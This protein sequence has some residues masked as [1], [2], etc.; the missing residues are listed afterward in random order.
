MSETVIETKLVIT[1]KL[2]GKSPWFPE[3]K[4][5]E[6]ITFVK[7]ERLGRDFT[8]YVSG[9][10]LDLRTGHSFS[11]NGSYL[12]KMVMERNNESESAFEVALQDSQDDEDKPKK[13]KVKEGDGLLCQPIVHIGLPPVSGFS[14]KKVRCLWGVR[15]MPLWVEAVA[16]SLEHIRAGILDASDGERRTRQSNKRRRVSNQE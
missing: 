6:G 9:R 4:V 3:A 7:L 5:V 2:N 12:Q 8:R 15:A 13:R 14:N 11:L 10:S 16:E 1:N